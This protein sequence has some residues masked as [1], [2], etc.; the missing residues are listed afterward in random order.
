MADGLPKIPS[1]WF[2]MDDLEHFLV[3]EMPESR[4]QVSIR[5][6][7]ICCIEGPHSSGVASKPANR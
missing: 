2:G 4:Q 6:V 7:L 5:L 3:Q 1:C